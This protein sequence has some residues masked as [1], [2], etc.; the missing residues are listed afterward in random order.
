MKKTSIA[1]VLILAFF[2]AFA[3]VAIAQMAAKGW[4]KTVTLSSGE[5]ILDMSGEWDDLSGGYGIFSWH[6]GSPE[7]LT[8]TQ[9][10]NTFTAVKQIGSRWVP[11]GAASIK[12]ELD[13]HGFK[14]VYAYI[15]C[16]AMDGTFDWEE[17]KWEISEKGNKVDLDCGERIKKTLTRR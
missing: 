13:K 4:E 7:I 9:E 14:V 1:P 2:I 12:G 6:K 16:E 11:K 17:C 15:G 5:V 10:G 8:I 3:S